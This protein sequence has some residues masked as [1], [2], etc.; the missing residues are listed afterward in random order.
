MG[1]IGIS[2]VLIAF[3]G[4]SQDD[5]TYIEKIK[6]ISQLIEKLDSEDEK[7]RSNA[8]D[9]LIQNNPKDITPLLEKRIFE[10]RFSLHYELLKKCL[11]NV[12]YCSTY[13]LI[14]S[15][16]ILAIILKLEDLLKTDKN[17]YLLNKLNDLRNNLNMKNLEQALEIA[18][19]IETL[20]KSEIKDLARKLK[21]AIDENIF[22]QT[23]IQTE[24][25]FDKKIYVEGE[26]PEFTIK[27]INLQ[28]RKI[29]LLFPQ[30][31]TSN[32]IIKVDINQYDIYLNKTS[33]YFAT[34]RK[35]DEIIL[36]PNGTWQTT[37]KLDELVNFLL[38][39]PIALCTANALTITAKFD[40][41]QDVFYKK[42]LFQPYSFIIITKH[43][44]KF[45][46][47]TS[48]TFSNLLETGSIE[49]VLVCAVIAV[50]SD[51]QTRKFALSLMI[52]AIKTIGMDQQTVQQKVRFN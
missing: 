6:K 26:V 11:M 29:K 8:F 43:D 37:V 9:E 50:Y 42:V 14:N 34:N 28:P 22:N 46:E 16:E 41:G 18:S 15:D 25:S 30:K 32:L 49:D 40:N 2:A 7:E 27:I 45:L 47:N 23:V 10:S 5:A 39:Q 4:F 13:N 51:K 36:P 12:A 24:I 52:E 35:T 17:Q 3:I 20:E 48:G 19:A 21:L 38:S 44:K 1:N 31:A 33:D